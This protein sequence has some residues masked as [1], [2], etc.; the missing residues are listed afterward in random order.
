MAKV[1]L[2]F[3]G[4]GWW[5]TTNHMPLLS[6]RSDVEMYG[7]AS[8]GQDMLAKVKDMFGFQFV[9]EDYHELLEHRLDG[10]IVSTPHYLHYEH[11]K[12]A[13]EKGFHVLCEKPMVL[14]AA[15][16]WEL[17]NIAKSKGVEILIPY[18]WNYKPFT[19]QAKKFI[20]GGAVGNIEYVL[21]HMASPTKALFGGGVSRFEHWLPTLAEPDPRTWQDP[22]KGGGYAHGQIT[23]SSGLLF[24]LTNLRASEVAA[25]MTSPNSEVDMYDAASVVFESGAIGS[26][27]GAATLPE[28]DLY[29]VDLRIFGDEGVVLLD[30]ERERLEVR[31]HDKKHQHFDI[32][33]GEGAYL[34]D[35]PP[36]RFVDVI[37]GKG[38]N[39]SPGEVGAK[40]VE[41]IEAMI[42]SAKNSGYPTKVYR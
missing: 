27:S 11:A 13:V 34:C 1:R 21:C 41:L 10:V 32:P 15:E 22:E 20:E 37:L 7:V 4:A 16:A 26:F 3:I 29:Q 14:H 42:R 39:D 12:A 6:K 25:R 8:L 18:G 38:I 23:H 17:V 30:V 31:R 28:G 9:T 40:T 19:R 36:N 5:A 35:E 33:A 24:W 2:G